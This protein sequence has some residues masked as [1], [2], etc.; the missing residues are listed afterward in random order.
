MKAL[1]RSL[2]ATGLGSGLLLSASL[3]GAAEGDPCYNDD[4]CA[5]PACGGEVCNWGKLAMKADG[6]KIFYCQPAGKEA[7]GTDGWCTDDTDC[8]CKAEG[9]TCQLGADMATKNHCTATQSTSAP[10]G[11]SG[12]GGSAS[13]AGTSSTAGTPGT[14]GTA[15]TAGAGGTAAK[16]DDGGGCSVAT[17]AST[18]GGIALAL[19]MLG[20]GFA[21]ARRRR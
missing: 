3:A 9:A 5:N 21:V 11:G 1:L 8:K 4:D 19:G 7:K 18:G 15:S 20:L 13:T 17:P 2:L 6:M 12:A 10:V 16:E 14:A